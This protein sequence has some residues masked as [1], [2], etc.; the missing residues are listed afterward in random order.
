MRKINFKI[1]TAP[2]LFL[3]KTQKIMNAQNPFCSHFDVLFK[4]NF[5]V[6]KSN[7]F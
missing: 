2:V 6:K 5:L 3:D 4:H 1:C 7:F